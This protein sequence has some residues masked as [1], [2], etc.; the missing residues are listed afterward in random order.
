MIMKDFNWKEFKEGKIVVHCPKEYL[1]EHFLSKC[2]KNG[3]IDNE[4]RSEFLDNWNRYK[5]NTCYTT[6]GRFSYDRLDYYKTCKYYN[7]IIEWKFNPK[8]KED[9]EEIAKFITR[10]K[11]NGMVD[12]HELL[13][14]YCPSDVTLAN[15]C[16]WN[17]CI[18]CWS[19]AV[20]SIQFKGD[21]EETIQTNNK[22]E[23]DNKME[24]NELKNK[25]AELETTT[26]KAIEEL[27]V[28]LEKKKNEIKAAKIEKVRKPEY[29]ETYYFIDS[30]GKVIMSEWTNHE[31]D[32]SRYSLGNCF[33]T[34]Q[35]A[36]K[37]RDKLILI[38][39]LKRFAEENNEGEIYWNNENQYK[40]S[41][42]YNFDDENMDT[43]CHCIYKESILP[44][45]TSEEKA[46]KAIDT[47]KDR[48]I[49]LFIEQQ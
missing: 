19:N 16:S 4:E 2:T 17:D 27:K 33:K 21:K 34:R 11:F 9:I 47:F 26:S 15:N 5:E 40:W 31:Y 49:K 46:R 1:A 6:Y 25:L 18:D 41:V 43:E 29:K 23:G 8:N 39:D 38:V 13:S 45:F 37:A 36:E 28:A 14:G 44:Y 24:L 30:E 35:E 22:L 48:L 20:K 10:D 12:S 7:K 32:K 3:I 42:M